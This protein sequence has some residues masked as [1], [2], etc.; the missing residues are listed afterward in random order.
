[1]PT[2]AKTIDVAAP[3]EEAFGYVADFRTVTEWDPGIVKAQRVNNGPIGL[4]ATYDVMALFRGK[5]LPFRYEVS[6][7][8]E[9]R[10]LLFHGA[11]AKARSV[12]EILFERAGSGTRIT[13]RAVVTMKGIYR[14]AGPLLGPTFDEMGSR[15]LAGLKAKLDGAR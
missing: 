4:G 15:A 9:G 7:Y 2:F 11:G 10:R 5:P 8:E 12:D 1:V 14:L 3:L 6:A 13:Y